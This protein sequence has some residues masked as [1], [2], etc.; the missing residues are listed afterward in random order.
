MGQ[1]DQSGRPE[2]IRA[3]TLDVHAP[4]N[5]GPAIEMH[6]RQGGHFMRAIRQR[7]EH[8]IVWRDFQ[9]SDPPSHVVCPIQPRSA[10]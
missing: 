5:G 8:Q 1:A 10:G 7:T 3:R 2:S 9:I 6:V 4:Q